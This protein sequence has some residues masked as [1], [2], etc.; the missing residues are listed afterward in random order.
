LQNR[1]LA[2]SHLLAEVSPDGLLNS[3]SHCPAQILQLLSK[4]FQLAPQESWA[5]NSFLHSWNIL[6]AFTT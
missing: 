3:S 4:R 5:M 1:G 6:L 2:G